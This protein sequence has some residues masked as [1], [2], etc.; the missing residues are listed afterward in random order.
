MG[1]SV[2][3]A[4]TPAPQPK[5]PEWLVFQFRI[6]V[7][8]SKDIVASIREQAIQAE[9]PPEFLADLVTGVLKANNTYPQDLASK[10]YVPCTDAY[11]FPDAMFVKVQAV[12]CMD[13]PPKTRH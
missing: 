13:A 8:S 3:H 10:E 12:V 1:C 6:T 5:L 4:K 2:S 9:F 7:R 11:Y